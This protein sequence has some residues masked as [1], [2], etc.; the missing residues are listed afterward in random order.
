M[1]R[2]IAST[3]DAPLT[4][5][6]ER[7]YGL[8]IRR[9]AN[10]CRFLQTRSDWTLSPKDEELIRDPDFCAGRSLIVAPDSRII[11]GPLGNEEAILYAD[12]DLD[13]GV[14]MKL[15]RDFAGR[16]NR[17]GIFQV[18]VNAKAPHIFAIANATPNGWGEAPAVVPG[19]HDETVAIEPIHQRA[20]G[21]GGGG[22]I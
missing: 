2:N 3:K 1:F 5:R 7:A 4:M 19:G 17:P 18:T 14:R 21:L 9:L 11:A 20:I 10:V 13:I 12:L 15:L 16:Y 22:D 6:S 8:T